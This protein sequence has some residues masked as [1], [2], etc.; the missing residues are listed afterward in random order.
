MRIK[1]ILTKWNDD[2]GYGFITPFRKKKEIFVHINEFL[3]K[4]KRPTVNQNLTFSISHSKKSKPYAINV[5]IDDNSLTIR[6]KGIITTWNDNKGYGFIT[7]LGEKKEIFIHV[8][9]F[10]GHPSI[11]DKIIFT[12]SKDKNG[13]ECAINATR[14][15]KI[16]LTLEEEEP[17][18]INILSIFLISIFYLML[19]YFSTKGTLKISIIPYYISMGILTFFIYSTD[20]NYAKEGSWRISEKTLHILSIIGGW[21]GALIAQNKLRHKSSKSSFQIIFLFTV[22]FN[23]ILLFYFK[24]SF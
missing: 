4:Q 22:L 23:L 15:S 3:N 18:H 9:E 6:K 1:G 20:K 5:K 19:F 16:K 11:N 13:R 2:K 21:T 24:N 14:F 12:L 17:N 8:T 7:P 10:R